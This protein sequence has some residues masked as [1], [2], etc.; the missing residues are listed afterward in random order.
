[1]TGIIHLDFPLFLPLASAAAYIPTTTPSQI[2]SKMPLMMTHSLHHL[3]PQHPLPFLIKG[4]ILE[5]I[6]TL[7]SD[8]VMLTGS[9]IP[10][11]TAILILLNQS[12]EAAL[13][14]HVVSILLSFSQSM[15][16]FPYHLGAKRSLT[17]LTR[18]SVSLGCSFL[19]LY[20]IYMGLPELITVYIMRCINL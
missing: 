7:C 17:H 3:H 18:L 16:L 1:M 10:A 12:P 19:V 20:C 6:I 2:T 13:L 11:P 4:S 9:F 14:P 5:Q 15:I 8:L